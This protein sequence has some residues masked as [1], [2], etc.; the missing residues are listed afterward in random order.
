M[1]ADQRLEGPGTGAWY[2]RIGVWDFAA[3]ELA[4]MPGI[5]VKVKK[6]GTAAEWAKVQEALRRELDKKKERAERS[7]LRFT[8]D[9]CSGAR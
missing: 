6:N 5:E 1:K 2:E 8:P 7:R 4:G 9:R 3:L